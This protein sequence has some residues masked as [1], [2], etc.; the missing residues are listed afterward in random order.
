MADVL[1]TLLVLIKADSNQL[2]RELNRVERESA[3]TKAKVSRNL[4]FGSIGGNLTGL[5]GSGGI[6]FALREMAGESARTEA[7]L[8]SFDNTVQRMGLSGDEAS[9][10]VRQIASEFGLLESQVQ[11]AST[12]LLKMGV[13]VETTGETLRSLAASAGLLGSDIATAMT[14][15]AQGVALQRS[16]LLET[17][18]I[19]V[20][21][22]QTW[23]PYAAE[24]GKATSALSDNEKVLAFARGV[25]REAKPD[26]DD[27]ADSFG[28]FARGQAEVRAELAE[29]VNTIGRF[30]Q[31]G[32]IPVNAAVKESASFFNELPEPVQRTATAM[33]AAGAGAAALAAGAG[34]LALVL[35]PLSGPVGL[36]V[37]AAVGIAGLVAATETAPTPIRE[38]KDALGELKEANETY[39]TAVVNA[40]DAETA[41]AEQRLRNA[42]TTV[43]ADLKVA[44]GKLAQAEAQLAAAEQAGKTNPEGYSF[45]APELA[46]NVE[47]YR[48]TVRQLEAELQNAKTTLTGGLSRID[49]LR[50][51]GLGGST[52]DGS[53]TTPP[54][55][56]GTKTAAQ[57]LNEVGE[58]GTRANER[59]EL[60]GNTLETQLGAAEE[61]AGLLSGALDDLLAMPDATP[62]MLTNIAERLT[63][64]QEE[65]KTLTT[66]LENLANAPVPGDVGRVDDL[67]AAGLS[68]GDPGGSRLDEVFAD[69]SERTRV[70][71]EFAEG[72]ERAEAA[73][74][75]RADAERI[76]NDTLAAQSERQRELLE[77]AR[78]IST[79]TTSAQAGAATDRLFDP[80]L[81]R[82]GLRQSQVDFGNQEDGGRDFQ[83]TVNQFTG[84][85]EQ[86]AELADSIRL[87]GVEGD[88]TTR[89][90]TELLEQVEKLS[91]KVVNITI[92]TTAET[93]VPLTGPGGAQPTA[94]FDRSKG[95]KTGDVEISKEDD[96]SRFFDANN[97]LILN[98][99]E[100][101]NL[102][103]GQA[104]LDFA[105]NVANALAD[106]KI[107]GGEAAGIGGALGGAAG[108]A[109]AAALGL[110]PQ[111]GSIVGELLGGFVGSLFGGSEETADARRKE[112]DLDRR[113]DVQTISILLS[114]Q[115]SN[116]FTGNLSEPQNRAALRGQTG[117]VIQTLRD[118]LP[119]DRPK[120][121]G[122]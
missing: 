88:I 28:V 3:D 41:A 57:V 71:G 42:S 40:S 61:R 110:P 90:M 30:A 46:F 27:F 87:A 89:K 56:T 25:I 121:R 94:E 21:A 117:D 96:F 1:E 14:T 122:R 20:N 109:G 62:A 37:L 34:T 35:G 106:G 15:G 98:A 23:G 16:E 13:D 103:V 59:A 81:G 31:E 2:Q 112:S 68:R 95:L 86:L 22:S 70:T 69:S 58:A 10:M 73:A 48:E 7:S 33:V 5:A 19:L 80:N 75:Q 79:D 78:A 115:Q 43:E 116:T 67:R 100:Q 17:S 111:L 8:R 60:L 39:Q 12:P 38:L 82:G 52:A 102:S 4:D 9:K 101:F 105:G 45:V 74:R 93:D 51:K 6:L 113:G 107:S 55:P 77:Q 114:F 11:E 66:A 54:P 118:V 65:V 32:L 36:F 72:Q 85:D 97:D 99:G 50:A 84:S 18:G 119:L 44:R 108:A 26:V 83:N 63:T 64:A 120:V 104:G 29:S 47:A 91:G 24:V 49:L 53:T 76:L 92:K